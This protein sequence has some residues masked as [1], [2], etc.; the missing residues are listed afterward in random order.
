MSYDYYREQENDRIRMQQIRERD[1]MMLDNL[2]N[3]SIQSG[4][5]NQPFPVNYGNTAGPGLIGLLIGLLFG[6]R[7]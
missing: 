3:Q 2:Y 1:Q 6:R 7:Y 4:F 5:R